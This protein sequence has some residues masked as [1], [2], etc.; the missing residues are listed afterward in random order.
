[1]TRPVSGSVRLAPEYQFGA[2]GSQALRLMDFYLE[3]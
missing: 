3:I 2:T 1:M